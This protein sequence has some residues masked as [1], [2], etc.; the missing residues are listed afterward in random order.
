MTASENW[1]DWSS[2]EIESHIDGLIAAEPGM[3]ND[4]NILQDIF[5][6]IDF[7][8]L[9][10]SDNQEKVDHFCRRAIAFGNQGL[11]PPA[12]VCVYP[13]FV[14]QAKSL[15]EGTG[16]RVAAVSGY[17]PS[18]QA[19]LRLKLDEVRFTADEGADE[20]DF[21]INRGKFLEGERQYVFEEIASAKVIL[22]DIHL[23]VILETGEL[24]TTDNIWKASEIAMEAGADFIKTSTGKFHPAATEHAAFI[25]LNTIRDHYRKTGRKIGFKPAGGIAEAMQALRYFLLTRDILGNDWITKDLFRIGASRLAD[26]LSDAMAD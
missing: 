3:I 8:T 10:G 2:T 23:K 16:I 26:N 24:R 18:G 9:E 4:R 13:G 19:S 17:F 21:V 12:A 1:Y 15:L 5:S 7:T 20:I 6:C 11:P 14:R 22:K 25:M